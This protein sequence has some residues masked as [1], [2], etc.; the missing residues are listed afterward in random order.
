MLFDLARYLRWI[1]PIDTPDDDL[2]PIVRRWHEQALP[3]IATKAWDATW[4]DFQRAWGYRW[5]TS[6]FLARVSRRAAA[7][8]YEVGNRDMIQDRVAAVYRAAHIECGETTF[9]LDCRAVGGMAGVSH[10]TANTHAMRLVHEEGLLRKIE[11]ARFGRKPENRRAT[12]WTWQDH[13]ARRMGSDRTQPD[14]Q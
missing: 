5:S 13:H 9:Y 2:I 3:A 8:P 10:T 11:P 1:Y 14:D 7:E 6:G 12:V 4:S